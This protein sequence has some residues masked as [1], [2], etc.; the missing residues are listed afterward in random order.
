[1]FREIYERITSRDV[2]AW[3]VVIF[4]AFM[5]S[6]GVYT[7]ISQPGALVATSSG[8]SSFI[9]KSTSSATVTEMIASFILILVGF[10][11]FLV[12]QSAM[13]K[14]YDL[15]SSRIRYLGGMVLIVLAVLL[16]ETITY[17]KI[18]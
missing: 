15:S 12:L 17:I 8:G 10:M 9:A 7:I 14:N 1:M 2:I 4:M 11:G 16:L 6:G 18:H 13:R 3:A 5:L